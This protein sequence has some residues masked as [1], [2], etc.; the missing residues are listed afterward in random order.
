MSRGSWTYWRTPKHHPVLIHCE[1]GS[2]RT[3]FAT[4]AFRIVFDG[5]SY[6]KAM[7]EARDLDFPTPH[8][9]I[10]REYDKILREL[11]DRKAGWAAT[12]GSGPASRP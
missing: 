7:E 11:A 4:A 10:D 2:A 12:P 9:D 5:W 3:G 8:K 1:A 6:E